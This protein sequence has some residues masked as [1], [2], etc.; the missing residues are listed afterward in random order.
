[1]KRTLVLALCLSASTAAFAQR[2]A[3]A[4]EWTHVYMN[5]RATFQNSYD[6][7]ESMLRI[8]LYVNA[9]GNGLSFSGQ[10]FS[11]S[12]NLTGNWWSIYAGGASANISL[13]GDDYNIDARIP[14]RN[15]APARFLRLTMYSQGPADNPNFPPSYSI[16]DADLSLQINPAGSNGYTISGRVNTEKVGPEGTAIV[17]LVTSAIM[18]SR[19]PKA[20]GIPKPEAVEKSMRSD[21]AVM[22]PAQ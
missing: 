10:P 2:A 4:N 18:H 3:P 16:Y 20:N 7:Q 21:P 5:V 15:G 13:W 14:G 6:I 22:V 1:M 12:M 11:G 8:F 9:F 17:G 19:K